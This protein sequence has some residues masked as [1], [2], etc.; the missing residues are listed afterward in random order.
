MQTTVSSPNHPTISHSTS[1]RIQLRNTMLHEVPEIMTIRQ[2]LSCSGCPFACHGWA[3]PRR[4]TDAWGSRHPRSIVP[5]HD[6]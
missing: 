1:L 2:R 3:A 5:L 4:A 6:V